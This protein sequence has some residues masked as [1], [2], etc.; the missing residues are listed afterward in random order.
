MN[1]LRTTLDNGIK[2]LILER[3]TAPVVSFWIWYRV[4]S[5]NEHLGRT[6]I[7]HWTEH[8]LFK[9]TDRW[10]Q[11]TAYKAIS[12]EGGTFNGMTWMDF[13]TFY[14]SL[15]VDKLSLSLDIES[16]R[17]Q[18][19]TISEADVEAERAVIMS[20]RAGQENSPLF[21]L[22]EEVSAAAFR[23]HPYRYEIVGHICD[24]K[25]I[26]YNDLQQHYHTYYTP[27]NAIIA[28]AGAVNAVETEHLISRYFKSIRSEITP[29]KVSSKEPKQR[30]ERRIKVE[31]AGHTNYMEVV[32]HI[33]SANH[34]DFYA[35][36]VMNAVLTGGSGFLVG[37]G[38]MTNH[39]SRLYRS[40][41]DSELALDINGNMMPTIDP[42]L[43]R[44]MTTL[45]PGKDTRD[46]ENALWTEID[47]LHNDFV[48]HNELEKAHQQ[49]RA[50]F[51]YASES[52]TY[53][54]FWL[55]FTE[56][57]SDYSWYLHYLENII[58]VTS[59]DIQR[60]AQTY[61]NSSNRT[62]GWYIGNSA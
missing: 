42:G 60:V 50:L 18:N 21:L 27:K 34:K 17:M 23:V 9:G 4:G 24:I 44:L 52:I 1:L 62:V 29:P 10:P 28:V 40:L 20:E 32:Y 49:A 26:T 14:E 47:R 2:V 3:H 45:W 33:P 30:G 38:S 6:G 53:Q 8:M 15:P 11:G 54:A 51:A 48:T 41:V 12:R 22:G 43:Y 35:L 46:V 56:Q 61:L 58:A 59:E 36:T 13:T 37:R 19:C 7:S 31:G 39:T 16:D 55:G 5:R 57:F 25:N